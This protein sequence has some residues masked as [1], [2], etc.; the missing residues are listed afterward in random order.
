MRNGLIWVLMLTFC[1]S[2]S[3]DELLSSCRS[4]CS[5]QASSSCLDRDTVCR[6]GNVMDRW[7]DG[8]VLWLK[9]C[10][11]SLHFGVCVCV[12]SWA[13]LSVSFQVCSSVVCPTLWS[14]DWLLAGIK[15]DSTSSLVQTFLFLTCDV[16]GILLCALPYSAVFTDGFC[17]SCVLSGA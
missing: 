17:S 8:R 5:R 12:C 15:Q 10:F 2:A 14:A 6:W 13:L 7:T 1:G 3:S 16:F 4:R 11:L 9:W